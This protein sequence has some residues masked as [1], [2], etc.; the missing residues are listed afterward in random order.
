MKIVYDKKL[1]YRDFRKHTD[2]VKDE[3]KDNGLMEV[4]LGD[5]IVKKIKA[6]KSE[7]NLKTNINEMKK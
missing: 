3:L 5:L 1:F 2:Q 7:H 4:N 6:D